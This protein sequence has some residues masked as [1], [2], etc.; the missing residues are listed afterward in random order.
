MKIT[1]RQLKRI[2]KE[3]KAKILS[4]ALNYAGTSADT[5]G[6]TEQEFAQIANRFGWELA[7]IDGEIEDDVGSGQW[8]AIFTTADESR[9]EINYSYVYHPFRRDDDMEY[10]L[11][12][13]SGEI[14]GSFQS[15]GWHDDLIAI[16]Q[17]FNRA[18]V[19]DLEQ[20]KSL[21]ERG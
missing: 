7:S 2:I 11:K 6:G 19:V 20:F 9:L 17:A 14:E 5:F 15:E 18:R 1:K 3:E 4:E 12:T 16:F 10:Y 13:A 8:T 21:V